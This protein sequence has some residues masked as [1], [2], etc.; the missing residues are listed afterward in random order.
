MTTT[1]RP[2]AGCTGRSHWCPVSRR[3]PVTVTVAVTLLALSA[4][5]GDDGR[6]ATAGAPARP[7]AGEEAP[8]EPT[9]EAL[10]WGPTEAG[11]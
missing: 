8:A 1:G 6:D 7:T 4:C 2:R 9:P 10:S 5:G 3:L 11:W